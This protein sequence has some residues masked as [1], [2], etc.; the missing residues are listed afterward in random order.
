MTPLRSTADGTAELYDRMSR[1][2]HNRRS[3]CVDAVWEPGRT[4]AYG[5]SPSAIRRAGYASWA[6]VMTDEALIAVGE[7]LTT[8]CWPKDLFGERIT[9]L[10]QSIAAMRRTAPLGEPSIREAA[11]TLAGLA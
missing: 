1:V 10:Q 6:G 7:A 3:S 4:M 2:G 5:R 8:L 11:G 9:P